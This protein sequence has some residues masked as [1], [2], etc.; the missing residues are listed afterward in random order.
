MFGKK[1]NQAQDKQI[2]SLSQN[3]HQAITVYN[4]GFKDVNQRLANIEKQ[5]ADILKHLN[6][7]EAHDK[8]QDSQIIDF[9]NQFN[10]AIK[11]LKAKAHEHTVTEA[12][13]T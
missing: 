7:K 2:Q 13:P 3:L 9:V 5:Q 4:K 11:D 8:Q 6:S 1:E 12:T 10:N